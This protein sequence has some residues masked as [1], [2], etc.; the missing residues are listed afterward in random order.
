MNYP[1]KNDS[2]R[3]MLQHPPA[4]NDDTFLSLYDLGGC[5]SLICHG[6]ELL[7]IDKKNPSKAL[8]IFRREKGIEEVINAYWAD[9]LD[10]KARRYFDSIKSVKNR[11]YSSK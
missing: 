8:F 7:A 10:V 3:D 4:Y 2:D 9:K 11:L 6:Y 5:A 1:E